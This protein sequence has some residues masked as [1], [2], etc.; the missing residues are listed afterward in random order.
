MGYIESRI[1]ADSGAV[2]TKVYLSA[3]NVNWTFIGNANPNGLVL[4]MA[5]YQAVHATGM[6]EARIMLAQVTTYLASS[7]K[8]NAAYKAINDALA[9]VEA[10]SFP[11]AV[12]LHLR[13]PVTGLMKKEGFG[14][15]YVYPHDHPGH[16]VE[17]DHLPPPYKDRIFYDPT[18][19]GREH[20]LK[21]RLQRWWGKRRKG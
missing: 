7:P 18:D 9:A 19:E 6:P 16:F 1:W 14:Q 4:A 12:P 10:E 15:G 13:N 2:G 5:G 17:Q 11:A 8:S 20:E 21:E 3:N